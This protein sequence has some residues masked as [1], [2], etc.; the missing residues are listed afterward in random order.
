MRLRVN[1][2]KKQILNAAI[3]ALLVTGASCGVGHL[4]NDRGRPWLQPTQNP[5]Q[6]PNPGPG[7]GQDPDSQNPPNGDHDTPNTDPAP[8]PPEGP[9]NFSETKLRDT[10]YVGQ[11]A[12]EPG[13]PML[14]DRCGNRFIVRG[15]ET[16]LGQGQRDPGSQISYQGFIRTLQNAG[17]NAVRILPWMKT[18]EVEPPV[19][20]QELD[21]FLTELVAA[22]IVA[23]VNPS[24]GEDGITVDRYLDWFKRYVDVLVKH[25]S[26]LII[27]AFC[28]SNQKDGGYWERESRRSIKMLRDMR[29]SDGRKLDV[30]MAV[31][32]AGFGQQL[33]ITMQRAPSVLKADALRNTFFV[34]QAYWTKGG[35]EE[36]DFWRDYKAAGGRSVGQESMIDAMELVK[37][38]KDIHIQVGLLRH[39]FGQNPDYRAAMLA[40]ENG[41]QSTGKLGWLW[42]SLGGMN[43]QNDLTRSRTWDSIS[44]LGRE[45]IIDHPAS[46]QR[47]ALKVCVPKN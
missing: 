46:I 14:L 33:L 4:Q 32:S 28:E 21:Q 39:N 2:V 15:I 36:K 25:Q 10:M 9:A 26:H 44:D 19:S 18:G 8:K 34:W 12:A 6:T 1:D 41:G 13:R 7:P 47:T 17:V 30:P 5:T 40:A 29:S 31:M 38:L 37:G 3:A 16:P 45:V 35:W 22:N 24:I 42:W 23:F 11:N 27:D 43:V 20:P